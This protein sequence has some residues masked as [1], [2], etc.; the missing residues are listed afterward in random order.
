MV[1]V[2]AFTRVHENVV[3]VQAKLNHFNQDQNLLTAPA[4]DNVVRL[5]PP[6]NVG[7]DEIRIAL[8]AISAA[9]SGLAKNAAGA[10]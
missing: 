9:A 3:C 10:A 5:L 4:G 2:I 1:A 6:L 8:N 7:D